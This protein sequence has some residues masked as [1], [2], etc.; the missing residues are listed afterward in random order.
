MTD[1][2]RRNGITYWPETE[3]PREWLLAMG[4]DALLDA[5][6]LTILLRIGC[7]DWSAVQVAIG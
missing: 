7:R 4:P 2:V 5:H 3:R 1:N 6:L